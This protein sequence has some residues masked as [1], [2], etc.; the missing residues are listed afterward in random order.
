[1]KLR[2]YVTSIEDMDACGKYDYEIRA[3]EKELDK[4]RR[5]RKN[6][7]KEKRGGFRKTSYR[8]HSMDF[9]CCED[10]IRATRRYEKSD[11]KSQ[12]A[13][14]EA[15]AYIADTEVPDCVDMMGDLES[16]FFDEWPADEVCDPNEEKADMD[17]VRGYEEGYRRGYE[18]ARR[19]M[20][21]FLERTRM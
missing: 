4:N 9:L 7:K 14:A 16:E 21:M 12:L 11:F 1:M 15:D 20:K 3:H 2:F 13:E 5:R 6:L 8:R 17:Y 18:A 19:E 10:L